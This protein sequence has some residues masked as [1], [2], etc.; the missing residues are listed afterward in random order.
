MTGGREGHFGPR[1]PAGTLN[2]VGA[3][4]RSRI[5]RSGGAGCAG[6]AAGR[7]DVR[8]RRGQGRERPASLPPLVRRGRK[9]YLF[10]VD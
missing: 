4:A 9:L 5:G 3:A 1:R 10:I 6:P 2:P 7:A 8:P